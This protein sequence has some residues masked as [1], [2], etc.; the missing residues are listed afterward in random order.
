MIILRDKQFAVDNSKKI[1]DTVATNKAQTTVKEVKPVDMPEYMRHS[2]PE[3]ESEGRD[4][5]SAASNELSK[6]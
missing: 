2:L 1:T 4:F 5:M 6:L 3:P